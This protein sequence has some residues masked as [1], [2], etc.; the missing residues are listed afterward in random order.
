MHSSK[1]GLPSS[2][3]VSSNFS[4]VPRRSRKWTENTLFCRPKW[5]IT[6]GRLSV[7]SVKLA[8]AQGNAVERTGHEVQQALVVLNAAHDAPHTANWG[9]RRIVRVQGQLDIPLFSNWHNP[10]E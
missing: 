8:L 7:M 1:S 2:C 9:Q 5:R 4:A 6:S 10:L 3:Q